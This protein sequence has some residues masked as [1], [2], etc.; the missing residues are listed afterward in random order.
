M[1]VCIKHSYRNSKP[2]SC[3][4]AYKRVL[5][6]CIKYHPK[7]LGIKTHNLFSL[8]TCHLCGGW[9]GNLITGL[10][11]SAWLELNDVFFPKWVHSY[12]CQI[13]AGYHLRVWLG[14]SDILVLFCKG[15]TELV[16]LPWS[17][18]LRSKS[19]Y[20]RDKEWKLPKFLKPRSKNQYGIN[21]IITYT[22]FHWTIHAQ[23]RRMRITSHLLKM[24]G[25]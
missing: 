1:Q 23:I 7:L 4:D 14:L 21:R 22:L 6:C 8:L 13:G 20:S 16:S 25:V 2:D 19:K 18:Q 9:Q 5:F 11:A 24:Q 15:F 3:E 17:E 12:G 10:F